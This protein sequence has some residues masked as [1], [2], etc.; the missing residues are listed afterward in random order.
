MDIRQLEILL[1]VAEQG[2]FSGASR[3]LHTVQS[4]ISTHM[5]RLER[6][7]GST[8][9]D[10]A[11]G[12]LTAEGIAVAERARRIRAEVDAIVPD[13]AAM[14]DEITGTVRIGIIGTVGRWLL[15]PLIEG[16]GREYPLVN[17]HVVGATTTNLVPSV[18]D[19]RLHLALVNLPVDDPD[20]AAE[21][22]FDE[23]RLLAV[24]AASPLAQRTEVQPRELTDLGVMVAPS[25]TAFRD[26][27]DEG[28]RHQGISLNPAAEI[29]SMGLLVSVVAAGTAVALLPASAVPADGKMVGIPVPGLAPRLVGLVSNRRVPPS[30]TTRA[31]IPV[32]RDLTQAETERRPGLTWIGSAPH[33]TDVTDS[34]P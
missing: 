1:A 30:A 32:I 17:L 4:N 24:P 26:E 31:I 15:P 12:Q 10:R 8:L 14:R 7:V 5:A 21:S 13:L 28:L 6:E 2:S 16:L 34:R 3:E 20:L 23:A 11:S 9:V 19:G 27:I 25:G 29:D 22:L 33:G 18:V